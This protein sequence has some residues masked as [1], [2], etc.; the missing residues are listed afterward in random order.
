MMTNK[1][2]ALK[3]AI[4]YIEKQKIKLSFDTLKAKADALNACYKALE[5]PTVAKLND[6]Y[7]R[8]TYVEGLNQPAQEPVATIQQFERKWID[9][10]ALEQP[11][12]E[13]VNNCPNCGSWFTKEIH[14]IPAPLW[15][16]LTDGELKDIRTL[17]DY[18]QY[19]SAGEWAYR[20]Q[21]ATE[22]ALK[23]KNT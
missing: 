18:S 15:Q 13:P 14:S 10:E 2:E 12:Q 3:M 11:A 20:V 22:Q 21:L 8:D 5:Q 7:L 1:D 9:E 23:D 19:E 4:E 16:G 17:C 6:E